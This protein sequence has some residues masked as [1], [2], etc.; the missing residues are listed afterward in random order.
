M[1]CT[2]AFSAL[3]LAA[4]GQAITLGQLDTFTT[5]TDN[6]IGS[7]PSLA[8]G[9]PGGAADQFLRLQ[10]GPGFSPKMAARN[11][12]QW[13]GNYPLA[14]VDS[15]TLQ[16]ANFGVSAIELRV[17]VFGSAGQEFTSTVSS[18][19]AADG[20]WRS[21]SFSLASSALTSVGA[22]NDYA[23]AMAGV[24]NFMFRHNPG[25]PTGAG[26]HPNF[27]GVMGIDNV[28]AV[29]EPTSLAV[30]AISCAVFRRRKR[31]RL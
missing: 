29:P 10:S 9:G 15:V 26:N 20:V 30:L 18:T 16:V 27:T 6:W 21:F 14:G 4:M 25:A 23:G 7:S 8:M 3:A 17:A 22:N 24:T 31:N 5:G 13:L 11:I 1:K 19:I 2:L 12:T 28:R